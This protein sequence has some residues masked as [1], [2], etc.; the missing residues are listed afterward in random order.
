MSEPIRTSNSAIHEESWRVRPL[1]GPDRAGRPLGAGVLLPG[2][3]VL[4]C[5]HVVLM[6]PDSS[7][8]RTPLEEVYVDVPHAPAGHTPEPLRARLLR[9]YLVMPTGQYGGDLALLK[10]DQEPAV[11]HAV[12]HRQIPARGDMVHFTGYP[13]DLPGGEHLDARLMGRGGP[14]PTPEW[15]QLDALNAPY[16]V[17]RGYSGCAVVHSRSRRVIG[18]VAHQFGTPQARVRRDHAYMIPTETV[19]KHL[20]LERLGLTVTG[21]PAVSHDVAVA[22]DRTASGR[23]PGLHRRLTR[24]LDGAPDT[25]PVEPVFAGEGEHDVLHTVRSVLTLAD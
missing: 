8:I 1:R 24:W 20:P 4:T 23:V 10:L 16:V 15:V 11:P 25:D 7:G 6:R 13:E 22:H 2:G 9:E 3:L 18:I 21:K 19:L 14:A 17:R 12:L 5:A